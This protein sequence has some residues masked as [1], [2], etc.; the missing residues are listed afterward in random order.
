MGT[1]GQDADSAGDAAAQEDVPEHVEL[2]DHSGLRRQLQEH[3]EKVHPCSVTCLA[4]VVHAVA[5]QALLESP[6][7]P[8]PRGSRKALDSALCNSY[9]TLCRLLRVLDTN[10]PG[11]WTTFAWSWA[12]SRAPLLTLCPEN[13]MIVS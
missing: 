10:Q 4:Q 9:R 5:R 2:T 8:H 3:A 11:C 7:G 12:F 13:L 1:S 6:A